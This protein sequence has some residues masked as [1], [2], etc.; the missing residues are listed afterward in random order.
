MPPKTKLKPN[1]VWKVER[2][3]EFGLG[4]VPR[5]E[6]DV[7]WGKI[8]HATYEE[9]II[10]ALIQRLTMLIAIVCVGFRASKER[11]ETTNTSKS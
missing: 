5:D 2:Q 6:N 11:G 1:L 10:C 7:Q 4:L 9:A 3:P 8:S